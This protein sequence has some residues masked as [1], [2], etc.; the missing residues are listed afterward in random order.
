MKHLEF[1]KQLIAA[2]KSLKVY[3]DNLA[4]DHEQANQLMQEILRHSR[5]MPQWHEERATSNEKNS[6][7][8][9]ATNCKWQ[10]PHYPTTHNR[11]MPYTFWATKTT[12]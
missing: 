6:D 2:T 7:T 3:S 1:Q 4:I 5:P 11:F 9:N 12:K 8:P 10:S